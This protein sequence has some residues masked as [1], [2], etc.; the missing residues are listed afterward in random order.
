MNSSGCAP[1]DQILDAVW[2]RDIVV[3]AHTVDNFVSALRRKLGWTEQAGF[4]L[5]AVRGVGY[6]FTLRQGASR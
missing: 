5:A 4:E 6:R 2:G 3:D 1:R